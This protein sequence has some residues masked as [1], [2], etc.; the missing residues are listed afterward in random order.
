[1]D[2]KQKK[3]PEESIGANSEGLE[4]QTKECHSLAHTEN[5]KLSR[6]HCAVLQRY[7][8]IEQ[9]AKQKNGNNKI[10]CVWLRAHILLYVEQDY[11]AMVEV[12][13]EGHGSTKKGAIIWTW[14]RSC[15]ERFHRGHGFMLEMMGNE[16]IV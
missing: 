4:C 6:N 14:H 7:Q 13:V 1:M 11:G 10:V 16:E 3:E 12:C 8:D 2:E 15:Q 9:T 5:E